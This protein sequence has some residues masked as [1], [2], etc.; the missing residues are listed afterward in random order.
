[1]KSR[2]LAITRRRFLANSAKAASALT[3]A[4]L[5][6]QPRGARAEPRGLSANHKLNIAFTGGAGR[7]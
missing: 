6:V 4:N 2:Y 5:L 3:V 1:M 7:K